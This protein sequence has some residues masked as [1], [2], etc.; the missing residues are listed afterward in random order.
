MESVVDKQNKAH[1][2]AY[3]G[4]RDIIFGKRQ[5]SNA[6]ETNNVTPSNSFKQSTS[7]SLHKKGKTKFTDINKYQ[8]KKKEK[9]VK[10]SHLLL[11]LLLLFSFY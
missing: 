6:K 10:H 8:E 9:G 11:Q 2:H 1:I 7:N 3:K 5:A 4:I